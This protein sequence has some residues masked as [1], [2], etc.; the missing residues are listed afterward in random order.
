VVTAQASFAVR[1]LPDEPLSGRTLAAVVDNEVAGNFD[2]KLEN[3]PCENLLQNLGWIVP[4]CLTERFP[5]SS[6]VGAGTLF[7]TIFQMKCDKPDEAQFGIVR[8]MA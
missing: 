5:L 1:L 6:S 3:T 7:Q 2:Y 4:D 8:E